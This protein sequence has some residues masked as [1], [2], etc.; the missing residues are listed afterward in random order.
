M[1]A[2][3]TLSVVLVLFLIAWF[4]KRAK[5]L[6]DANT[7]AYEDTIREIRRMNNSEKPNS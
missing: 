4:I 6:K 3:G 1:G 2:I 5:R 7:K